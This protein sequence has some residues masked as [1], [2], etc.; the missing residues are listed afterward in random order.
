MLVKYIY[1]FSVSLITLSSC[2]SL[3]DKTKKNTV[4]T[5]ENVKKKNIINSSSPIVSS[6]I[7]NVFQ[8]KKLTDQIKK[9]VKRYYLGHGYTLFWRNNGNMKSAISYLKSLDTGNWL[10][11]EWLKKNKYPLIYIIDSANNKLKKWF[12][13]KIELSIFTI[14]LSTLVIKPKPKTLFLTKQ[15]FKTK[16]NFNQKVEFIQKE[17]EAK[18]ALIERY[19][20][21][22][23]TNYNHI[24]GSYNV[25]I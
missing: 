20:N 25:N 21:V 10:V 17:I 19:S 1:I 7:D 8:H 24:L 15:E 22:N 2:C 4:V 12:N 5:A 6:S 16:E 23:L 11:T 18:D 13:R 9:Y 3:L 14:K